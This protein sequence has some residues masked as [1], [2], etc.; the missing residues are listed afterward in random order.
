MRFTT[1]QDYHTMLRINR[2]LV[3]TIIDTPVV[4]YKLNQEITQVNSYGE[5]QSKVW[6]VGV[7]IPAIIK[8]EQQSPLADM[9]TINFVQKCEF[10]LLRQECQDRNIYPETGDIIEFFNDYWEINNVNENQLYAGR[11]ELNHSI[12]CETHLSRKTSLQL[13]RPQA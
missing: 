1:P 4:L 13:E 11:E 9:Q 2:E 3:N 7:Q 10:S 12:I 5:S 8:R 6:Y